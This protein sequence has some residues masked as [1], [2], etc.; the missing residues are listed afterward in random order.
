MGK[1][2]PLTDQIQ[3]TFFEIVR[4]ANPKFKKWLTQV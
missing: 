3:K 2:G 1:K 4:G